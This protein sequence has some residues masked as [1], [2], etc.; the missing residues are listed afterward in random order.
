MVLAGFWVLLE[1]VYPTSYTAEGNTSVDA[2][3]VW[4]VRVDS[5]KGIAYIIAGGFDASRCL[6]RGGCGKSRVTS[7]SRCKLW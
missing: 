6:I 2:M 7:L 1:P 4:L 3:A 5:F